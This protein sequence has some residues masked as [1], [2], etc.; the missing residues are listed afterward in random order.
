LLRHRAVLKPWK[1]D[2]RQTRK[3]ARLAEDRRR[4]VELRTRLVRMLLA[5]LKESFPQA[6]EWLEDL[7]KPLGAAFLLRWP[8]A[9]GPRPE[10]SRVR[11]MIA[12][13]LLTCQL[14]LLYS[15]SAA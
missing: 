9:Q 5:R 11:R 13:V 10:G 12:E 7:S 4:L 3:L 6:I 2:D 8:P 15:P 1:P 14:L